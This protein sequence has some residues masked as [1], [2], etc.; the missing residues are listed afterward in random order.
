MSD[1]KSLGIGK[2]T[3]GPGRGKGTL[4]KSTH[5]VRNA[6]LMVA[7]GLGGAPRMIEWAKEDPQNERLFWTQ[8]YPKVL[9]R[10]VKA[11]IAGGMTLT[12][13]NEFA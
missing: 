12:L 6:I 13:V 4:N 10:E 8:V 1:K 2:G 3:P 5:D 9:P 7:E 11:E